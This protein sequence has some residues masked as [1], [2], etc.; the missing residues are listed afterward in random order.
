MN[1]NYDPVT[2]NEHLAAWMSRPAFAPNHHSLVIGSRCGANLDRLGSRVARYLNEHD[3]E[4]RNYWHPFT[5][6]NLHRLA[7]DPFLRDLILAGPAVDHHP[8]PPDSHLDRVARRLAQLGGAVLEGEFSLDATNDLRDTF[9]ICLCDHSP[10]CLDPCH[11]LVNPSV[12]SR[13][14]L[15]SAIGDSFLDW[16]SRNPAAVTLRH[17][18]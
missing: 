17:A 12:F 2:S 10:V 11:L 7:G 3:P 4:P 14:S 16:T 1:V 13:E 5:M 18:V 6:D 9:R 8:G 15:V